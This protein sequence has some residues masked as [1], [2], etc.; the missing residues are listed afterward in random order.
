FIRWAWPDPAVSGWR[1]KGEEASFWAL[2][3]LGTHQIDLALWFSGS[4]D[5][6]EVKC[7]QR[8]REGIDEAA[9]VSLRLSSGALAHI[10]ASGT[11]RASSRILDAGEKGELE[12]IGTL[13]ARS[14]G[15]IFARTPRGAA[16]P[17]PF[18]TISP[19]EAQLRAFVTRVESRELSEDPTL[20]ANTRVL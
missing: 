3:A 7:L 12:A 10:S 20:I 2:S 14:D 8:P 15:E 16:T 18:E 17:L 6:S 19:Y 4:T 1:A 9:E 13:G 5:V 11:H